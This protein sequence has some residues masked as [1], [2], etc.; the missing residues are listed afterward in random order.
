MTIYLDLIIV[1][2]FLIDF[3][4]IQL[5][6][7]LSKQQT[8]GWRLT[9][10]ALF[11]ASIVI[12]TVLFPSS[13]L[14]H[15]VGK[16]ILS[17]F[18]IA[19]AFKVKTIRLFLK[20]WVIFYFVTFAIGG[21]IIGLHFLFQQPFQ[22]N[23]TNVLTVSTGFGTPISW[24][25]VTISFPCCWW[26]TRHTMDKQQLMNY[27]AKQLFSCQ[28]HIID[29][30]V[31]TTGYVDSANHL[32]DPVSRKP[33]VIID[34]NVINQLFSLEEITQL[35]NISEQLDLTIANERM[36]SKLRFIPFQD[37]SNN[38]GL[39]LV[40]KPRQIIVQNKE[41]VFSTK[42]FLVGLR[43]ESLSDDQQYHCL[44]N[45]NLF[46]RLQEIC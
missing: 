10:A 29:V 21:I 25:F 27:Q 16:L 40:I 33:I 15:P 46:T 11:A 22:V 8:R 24:L 23:Q 20:S 17:G 18:I 1:L 2:N 30:V 31:T 5:T 9:L 39:L 37:V 7:F 44:L 13:P 12:I 28:L 26:L 32:I 38:N 19:I 43:F 42:D 4:I 3:M 41:R 36:R 35:K 14:L 34:L 45:P 6:G